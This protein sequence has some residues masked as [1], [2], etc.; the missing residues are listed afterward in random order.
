MNQ[1]RL[2]LEYLIFADDFVMPVRAGFRN[3]PTLAADVNDDGIMNDSDL[4][5][6]SYAFGETDCTSLP[7][8]CIG[9][10]DD[11]KDIDGKDIALLALD[12]GSADCP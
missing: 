4:N 8:I 7:A 9:D 1:Y 11:D 3:H 5:S 2:G 12:F 10:T 6:F